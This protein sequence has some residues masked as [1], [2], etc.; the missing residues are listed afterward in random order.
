MTAR[1]L[2]ASLQRRLEDLWRSLDAPI[3]EHLQPG[4]TD[5]QM[6]ALTEPLGIS[7]PREAR[8]WWAWQNGVSKADGAEFGWHVRQVG[9][10]ISLIS[11]EESITNY[12]RIRALALTLAIPERPADDLWRPGWLLLVGSGGPPM[13]ACDCSD[14][15]RPNAPVHA[16]EWVDTDI[17]TPVA[18]SIGEYV[19]WWFDAI[20]VGY[21][22]FDR[23][24]RR[25]TGDN[26]AWP[27]EW[28]HTR[29]L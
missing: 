12:H 28:D 5:A 9:C 22:V 2:D 16:V 3:L 6:D 7:L 20:D 8:A 11:L 27:R 13:I 10:G 24:A 29:Y 17:L 1:M 26:E 15:S 21:W 14:P 23:D 18:G 19:A 25:W 4:L